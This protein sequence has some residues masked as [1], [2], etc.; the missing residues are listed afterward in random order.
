M[1]FAR[2]VL[3]MVLT[4]AIPY[5]SFSQGSETRT[6]TSSKKKKS[7]KS[8]KKMTWKKYYALCGGKNGSREKNFEKI[9]GRTIFWVGSVAEITKD[10]ALAENRRWAENVIRVKMEPS[11][12]LVADVRLRIPKEM[13]ER[14]MAFEK[15][16]FIGFKGKIMYLGTRL[17]DH[18]VEVEK[19][20]RA[21]PKR[22][23]KPSTEKRQK[24]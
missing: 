24:K 1:R 15:G 10:I 8:K 5:S 7:S 13:S 4:F 22:A 11:D 23:S 18:V 16:Q 14:M 19:F 3:I 6:Q 21:R 9:K 20:K 17:S 2:I 12:S